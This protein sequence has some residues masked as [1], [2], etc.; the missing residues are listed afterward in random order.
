VSEGWRGDLLRLGAVLSA[1]AAVVHLSV[2]RLHFDEYWLFGVLFVVSGVLQLAWAALI[3]RRRDDRRLLL[4]GV[5]LQ[6]GIV[7]V[8][9][10]SRTAGLPYGPEPWDPESVGPLDAV[11]SLD[12]VLIAVL[13]AVSVWAVRR[14]RL[15]VD[16][17]E[18]FALIATAGT[19]FMLAAGAGH[20]H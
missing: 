19:W 6:L 3:W 10:V 20:G 2:A 11:C 9:V 1:A 14:R 5:V 12:E 15:L 8:W 18:A 7:L 4:A 16:G 17:L 13:A